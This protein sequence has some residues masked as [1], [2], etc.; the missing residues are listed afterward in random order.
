MNKYN[1][2]KNKILIK[3][4]ICAAILSYDVDRSTLSD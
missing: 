2:I 3:R 1:A 4:V